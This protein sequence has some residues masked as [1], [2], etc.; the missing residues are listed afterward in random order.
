[1]DIRML[2]PPYVCQSQS[3]VYNPQLPIPT[4]LPQYSLHG[5]SNTSSLPARITQMP[6]LNFIPAC[7]QCLLI[8]YL[9]LGTFVETLVD[10]AIQGTTECLTDAL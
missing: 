10:A 9:R 7:I 1:M 8:V 6:T 4:P 5:I 3:F 2:H